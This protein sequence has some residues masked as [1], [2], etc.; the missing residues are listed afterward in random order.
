[1]QSMFIN[2]DNDTVLPDVCLHKI[3]SETL[4]RHMQTEKV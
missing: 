1:M 3:W 4:F 2:Y